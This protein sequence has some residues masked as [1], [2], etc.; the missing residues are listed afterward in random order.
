LVENE[1]LP[2][3]GTVWRTARGCMGLWVPGPSLLVV[4]F[5]GH[6]EAGFVQ[7]LLTAYHG[8]AKA[9]RAH[10]FFDAESL[11][12][13]DSALRTELTAAFFPDRANLGSLHVLVKSRLVVMGVSVANLALGGI[14]TSTSER[15]S[16]KAK[17][18]ACLFDSHVAGFSSRVL[19]VLQPPPAAGAV[20]SQ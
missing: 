16:F 6:G 18:D 13:Y 14:V 19:D 12:N 7:P 9:D 8:L 11:S 2:Q 3:Q 15:A 17:L 20:G 10:L 5:V 4:S 1:R